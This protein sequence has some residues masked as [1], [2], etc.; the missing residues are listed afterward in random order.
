MDNAALVASAIQEARE[1]FPEY[2]DGESDE[3]VLKAI[4]EAVRRAGWEVDHEDH[5]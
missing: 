1:T 4:V 5:T 2:F 3:A